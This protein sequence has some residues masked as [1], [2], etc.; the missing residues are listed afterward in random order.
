VKCWVC[1]RSARGYGHTDTRYKPG[2]PNRYISDWVFCSRRCQDAFHRL[3]GQW[4]HLKEINPDQEVTV[5]DPTKQEQ[6]AM[7]ASLRFF[8]EAASE[9]G[10]D[11]PLGQYSEAEALRVIQ[12]IIA[13]YQSAM[14][15]YHEGARVSA[16]GAATREASADPMT[17]D[18][19]FAGLKDDLPWE[20]GK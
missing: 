4:K 3:Y 13:G 7:R 20:D 15:E 17:Q 6:A 19:P 14:V 11:K 18:N 16:V 10:F 1:S 2:D 12:A 9:I 8:G 5:I